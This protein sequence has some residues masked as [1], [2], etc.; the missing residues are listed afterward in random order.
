MKNSTLNSSNRTIT[1]M[2]PHEIWP[3]DALDIE[4]QELSK[5]RNEDI[6]IKGKTGPIKEFEEN[7][8][9]F[10]ENQSKY[11]I[12]FNSGTSGLLAAYFAIGIKEGDVVLGPGLTYHAALSPVFSLQGSVR[13][14]DIDI[15]SRCIDFKEIEKNICESTKAIT[16]VHQW[17]YPCNMDE[18]IKIAQKYNLKIIEDCSHAHGSKYKGK[19]CGTFG[20]VAVFS[21]QTNK[22]IFA[23]EG[24][25]LVTNDKDIY[26]RATLLGHYRDRCKS[27]ILEK[28]LND[29]WA[30]G[31]GLKLRMSPFNAIVAKYSLQNFPKIKEGRHKCL[32]YFNERLKEVNYLQNIDISNN[33]DMGAW[34]GFKPL[35]KEGILQ[36]ISRDELVQILQKEGMEVSAPSGKCLAN[37]PLYSE[38]PDRM[39]PLQKTKVVNN[40]E[41]LPVCKYVEDNA[42]SLPTFY[43]WENDKIIIDQYI[44]VFKE[45]EYQHGKKQHTG[46]R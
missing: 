23:G 43:D 25:I 6:G 13:L 32:N 34:Y 24:G 31:F 26:Y 40:I 35:Y 7:F 21:L 33:V 1:K 37:Q 19:L 8:L 46:T 27:E 14:I 4:L 22:A 16:V 12:S 2:L 30:T 44:E 15:N 41:S 9:A 36:G 42:L 38:F 18:I 17:G 45:I 20:N 39:F 11:S 3:P 10:L 5:Q 28:E 29:Y